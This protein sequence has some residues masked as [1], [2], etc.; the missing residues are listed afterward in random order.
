MITRRTLLAGS[1]TL[2]AGI[3]PL[4]FA[5]CNETFGNRSF[6]AACHAA[7]SAGYTGMEIAPYT[8]SA[9]PREI[10]KIMREEGLTFVGL[11]ALLSEPAGL[12]ITTADAV[13]RRRSWDHLNRLVELCS[14]LGSNGVMVLGSGKQRSA[15]S[16]GSSVQEASKRLEEGLAALA[17]IARARGVTIVLEPLAPGLADVVNTLAEA[18]AI[19]ARIGNAGLATMFDTHNTAGEKEPAPV[20]IEKYFRYIR[21]VHVNEMDGRYPGSGH[22][23]F[24][25]VLNALRRLNYQRWVSVE[26]FDFTAGGDAIARESLRAL[27]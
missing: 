21:H 9:E 5:I 24:A 16:G 10:R 17:P 2:R 23:D 12:H 3:K 1:V 18:V 13:V 7:K 25:S 15:W 26:V 27:H 6:A 22:Y 8:L 4:R 11:H 20:L 14:S 19:V